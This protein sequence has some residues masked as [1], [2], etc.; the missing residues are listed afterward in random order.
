MGGEN[1][2]S[3]KSLYQ[4]IL[5]LKEQVKE[6][7]PLKQKVI[8]LQKTVQN[9][10][11]S[12]NVTE[13]I[14]DK[15]ENKCTMCGLDFNSKNRLKKHKIELHAKPIKCQNC[16]KMFMKNCELELHIRS[17]HEEVK[18]YKCDLC[19][20]R[21]VLKWRMVK[22]Q[23]SH[24]DPGR[25][26]CHYFNNRKTCPFD[27]LGCMFAH[28]TS[29]VCRFDKICKNKLCPFQH[30]EQ[31]KQNNDKEKEVETKEA[32]K[33]NITDN[34]DDLEIEMEQSNFQTSTPKKRKDECEDCA[35]Q[36]ECVECIVK[37]YEGKMVV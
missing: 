24:R 28:E 8:E 19:D 22:H 23:E 27:E 20:K 17:K 4:E 6:I 25:K 31:E 15:K 34:Y 36:S 35:N 21:F 26:K 2:L 14:S 10:N 37:R 11:N 5:I 9:M 7:K 12:R 1:K 29:E 18:D 33:F 16:D 32:D 30:T 13:E 3:M